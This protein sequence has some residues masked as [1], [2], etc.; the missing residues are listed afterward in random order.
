MSELEII[1]KDDYGISKRRLSPDIIP[2]KGMLGFLMKKGIA[3][4]EN[5]GNIILIGV[6]I[7]FF[8]MSALAFYIL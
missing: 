4:S 2:E 6:A 5:T 3:K 7:F 1:E 8:A